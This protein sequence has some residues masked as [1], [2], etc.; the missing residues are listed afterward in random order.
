MARIACRQLAPVVG[1]LAGNQRLVVET[2]TA[3]AGAG[4][5]VLVLPEL[6]TSG[7]VFESAAEVDSC[8]IT[9][10]DDRFG[11]WAA[12]I[13]GT[14]VII[15][16][17]AERGADGLFYNSAAVV[18]ATGVLAVYRKAHLWDREKLFFTPGSQPPPVVETRF[19]RIGVLVC[20]DLEFP[21]YTRRL[22]LE[23][24]DLIAAP[25]NWPRPSLP[26]GQANPL[27]V[28]AQATAR[29]NRVA[30][31]C[32]DRTGI[33]HGQEWNEGTVIVD[34]DGW[35]VAGAQHDDT[36]IADI[37]LTASRNKRT[38][39]RNHVFDDRRVELY[40]PA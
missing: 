39:P 2:I 29:I 24:A 23:G 5:D 9:A 20:Y 3:D 7:Y 4:A 32:C 26:A 31:A 40:G 33:E 13:R 35:V 37:D 6:V 10:A 1:D 8:A 30:V 27:V 25:M 28:I 36:A 21:E 11:E 34:P 17:F 19:G 15:A 22:A 12:A 18:D 38:S 14:S 16:G